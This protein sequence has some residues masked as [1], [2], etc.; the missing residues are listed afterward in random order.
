[1][2]HYYLY[3][4]TISR[5]CE[6]VSFCQW[7][8]R[9]YAYSI[10]VCNQLCWLA[11]ETC[12]LPSSQ[13]WTYYLSVRLRQTPPP[14]A[15]ATAASRSFEDNNTLFESLPFSNCWYLVLKLANHF[16]IHS[17]HHYVVLRTAIME[18]TQF[19]RKFEA[20]W[21]PNILDWKMWTQL[22]DADIAYF[23]NLSLLK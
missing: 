21:P 2:A 15:A 12:R 17:M 5:M 10:V 14:I 11:V 23:S 20:R 22:L 18:L 13:F 3:V 7:R 6:F 8:L 9:C 16:S 19:S 1:M 4:F